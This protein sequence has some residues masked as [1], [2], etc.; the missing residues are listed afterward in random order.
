MYMVEEDNE[1]ASNLL[2]DKYRPIILKIASYYFKEAKKYGLEYDDLVQEGYFGLYSAIKNYN[3]KE[4]A[5]F[6]TY[7]IL[8]IRSKILNC[9][10]TYNAD[11]YLSLNNSISLYENVYSVDDSNLIDLIEDKN[12]I[13]PLNILENYELEIQI[14]DFLYLLNFSQASV[15]ELKLN[16]FRSYEISKLLDISKKEVSNILFRIRKKIRVIISH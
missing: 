3:S 8:C 6:Y 13:L 15:F 14:K 10:R 16:G 5:V 9:L 2:F 1:D 11:R 4:N 12:A 7:A